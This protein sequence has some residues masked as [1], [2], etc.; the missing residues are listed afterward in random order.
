MEEN[1]K[2]EVSQDEIDMQ[3]FL[4]QIQEKCPVNIYNYGANE[5]A[6]LIIVGKYLMCKNRVELKDIFSKYALDNNVK[7]NSILFFDRH[8]IVELITIIGGAL[9]I[10]AFNNTN[11]DVYIEGILIQIA[12]FLSNV[13]TYEELTNYMNH[14][15]ND[16]I[17]ERYRTVDP[18]V[19]ERLRSILYKIWF[20]PYSKLDDIAREA[21][22]QYKKEL[23]ESVNNE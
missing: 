9:D 1:I 20:I 5:H 3:Q 7:N 4:N 21:I 6:K 2:K 12:N 19:L 22:S 14:F 15:V 10:P 11:N 17:H 13:H 23:G 8:H 16:N 18:K